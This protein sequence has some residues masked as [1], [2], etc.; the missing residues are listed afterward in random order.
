MTL[1]KQLLVEQ[2]EATVSQSTV[3]SPLLIVVVSF[4]LEHTL[5]EEVVRSLRDVRIL[6]STM[7]V[8]AIFASYRTLLRWVGFQGT[9]DGVSNYPSP[10]DFFLRALQTN[11]KRVGGPLRYAS[12][13]ETHI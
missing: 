7:K 8:G 12:K 11:L 9:Q 4:V 2:F 3:P 5:D 10:F 1:D 6:D 13:Y